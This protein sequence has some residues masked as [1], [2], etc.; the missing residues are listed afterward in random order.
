MKFI[1]VATENYIDKISTI[2]LSMR[3]YLIFAWV[4]LIGQN[5]AQSFFSL[6]CL[7]GARLNVLEHMNPKKKEN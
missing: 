3:N 2:L 7:S 6:V 1:Y 5:T 4:P